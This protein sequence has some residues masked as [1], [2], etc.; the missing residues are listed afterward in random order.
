MLIGSQAADPRHL[1]SIRRS[2]CPPLS[3]NYAERPE[4]ITSN[5][6]GAF[7]IG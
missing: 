1:Y 5:E 4:L 6:L 3:L 2:V 7:V